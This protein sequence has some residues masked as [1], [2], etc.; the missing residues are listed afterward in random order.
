MKNK[1]SIKQ[2]IKAYFILIVSGMLPYHSISFLKWVK[3]NNWV[4]NTTEH[5]W[6]KLGERTINI[7][8]EEE[9]YRHF[10]NYH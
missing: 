6:V 10:C 5:K 2:R 4:Y 7:C 9:L 1:L 3:D 8:T